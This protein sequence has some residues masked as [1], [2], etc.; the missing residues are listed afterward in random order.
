MKKNAKPKHAA[1]LK[2]A[3]AERLTNVNPLDID[4]DP[5]NPRFVPDE[6]GKTQRQVIEILLEQHNLSEIA[7]S[8]CAGGFVPLDPFIVVREKGKLTMIEGNRR[9][10]VIKLFLEPTL[11]PSRYAREWDDFR[12]RAANA[13]IE[14]M[15]KID[16]WLYP[17]RKAL[18]LVSYIGYRHVT[19]I[20][21]W[22]TEQRADYAAG[23]IEDGS[24]RWTYDTVA[25][26]MGTKAAYVE[27]L[28]V[29]HR[30]CEQAFK[31]DIDGADRMREKFGILLRLI[32]SGNVRTF[33]GIKLPGD[34]KKSHEPVTKPE[35]DFEDFIRWAFG[36]EAHRKI[37]EDSRD[38]TK[39]GQI[40]A[41]DESIRY[42]RASK[43]P[44]FERAW[45]KSGGRREGLVENLYAAEVRLEEA[46]ALVREYRD[47]DDVAKGVRRCASYMVQILRYFPN[48][49]R[50]EGLIVQDVATT[51][52]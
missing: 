4:L 10:A 32:Q 5:D 45:E 40:L 48:V 13:S 16:V 21:E 18:E 23:L 50:D 29:A 11:T 20:K 39:Y 6:R 36:T 51:G 24:G 46:V 7:E 52:K 8:I 2:G 44:S 28:Y 25:E 14:G 1:V 27:K 33:L 41:S 26:V 37:L 43:D 31:H 30:I 3:D 42:L 34:P 19:G 9:L 35:R 38:I 47:D 17:D 22:D 12:S 15:R 49:Q